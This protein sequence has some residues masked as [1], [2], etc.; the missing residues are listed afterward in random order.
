MSSSHWD[1][2]LLNQQMEHVTWNTWGRVY[3]GSRTSKSLFRWSLHYQSL[4]ILIIIDQSLLTSTY[5]VRKGSYMSASGSVDACICTTLFALYFTN[6]HFSISGPLSGFS[7]PAGRPC[8]QSGCWQVFPAVHG[9]GFQTWDG[10][11]DCARDSE[12]Q[13][14][15]CR[16]VA[17]EFRY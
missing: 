10:G 7:Q 6:D 16:P 4:R 3:T 8:R 2:C 15:K 13:P 9:L 1:P 11:N 5:F 17:E 14:G 12:D